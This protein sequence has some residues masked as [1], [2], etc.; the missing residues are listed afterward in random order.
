ME[1]GLDTLEVVKEGNVVKIIW[2]LIWSQILLFTF[3][4]CASELV[5]ETERNPG[6][7]ARVDSAVDYWGDRMSILDEL[8]D[9]LLAQEGRFDVCRWE[10]GSVT[11]WPREDVQVELDTERVREI[12][13]ELDI[14]IVLVRP[15]DESLPYL[16]GVELDVNV[17]WPPDE[18]T[19]HREPGQMH[20]TSS[21]M[22][23]IC[24]KRTGAPGPVFEGCPEW[25]D[26]GGGWYLMY[27]SYFNGLEDT[28][29][30][31]N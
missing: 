16:D 8:K 27:G 15:E 5:P 10:D 1:T 22:S 25:I 30:A 28:G 18:I 23:K 21:A 11:V 17:M 2:I 19:W 29:T 4:G 20:E 6:Y 12:M 13:K 9:I 7:D 24:Y 26:L 3:W 14:G 31:R